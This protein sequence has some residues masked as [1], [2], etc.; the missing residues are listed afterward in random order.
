MIFV[1]PVSYIFF[2]KYHSLKRGTKKVQIC[3]NLDNKVVGTH[4]N[5]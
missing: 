2:T 4:G 5:F 3:P 1:L